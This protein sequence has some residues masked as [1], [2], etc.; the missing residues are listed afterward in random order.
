MALTALTANIS[1]SIYAS[2]IMQ[3]ATRVRHHSD[4]PWIPGDT[5]PPRRSVAAG[6][7]RSAAAT[8]RARRWRESRGLPRCYQCYDRCHLHALQKPLATCITR[9]LHIASIASCV[10]VS[11]LACRLLILW[12]A[13]PPD[14]TERRRAHPRLQSPPTQKPT[15]LQRDRACQDLEARRSER[16]QQ[17]KEPSSLP[18]APR[19][20]STLMQA[21]LFRT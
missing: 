8:P 17:R 1:S 10:L 14:S 12:R 5:W 3:H 9:S 20:I 6:R 18:A 19:A 2:C 13:W 15:H 7:W 11:A 21:A 16:D 4:E